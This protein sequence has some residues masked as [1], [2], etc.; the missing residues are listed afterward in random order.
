[1]IP[2]VMNMLKEAPTFQ[3]DVETPSR[4][5]RIFGWIEEVSELTR[6]PRGTRIH[7]EQ[8]AP[9]AIYLIYRGRVEFS[10]LGSAAGELGTVLEAGEFFGELRLDEE[11]AKRVY[12]AQTLEESDVWVLRRERVLQLLQHRPDL[13]TRLKGMVAYK[14]DLLFLFHE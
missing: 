6:F 12:C 8:D 3:P 1:M 4:G 10:F 7:T 11:Q 9:D 13:V 14:Q 2:S 5:D